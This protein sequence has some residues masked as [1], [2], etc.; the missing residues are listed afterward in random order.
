MPSGVYERKPREGVDPA[1]REKRLYYKLSAEFRHL[2][3]LSPKKNPKQLAAFIS[4]K[5][6]Q[7]D[8][9]QG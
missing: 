4:W 8:F 3:G 9:W 5:K 1:A 6:N 2:Y 7:K